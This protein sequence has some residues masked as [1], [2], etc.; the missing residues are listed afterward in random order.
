MILSFFDGQKPGNEIEEASSVLGVSKESIH[1]FVQQITGNEA[2]LELEFGG[3]IFFFPEKTLIYTDKTIPNLRHYKATDF[4]YESTDFS[5]VRYNIPSA[6]TFILNNVC[7]TDCYYCYADR[8]KKVHNEIPFER[9]KQLLH[10]LKESTIA[11]VDLIGGEVFHY[12]HWKELLLELKALA[13]TPPY[14]STKIPIKDDTIGFLKDIKHPDIQISLD[15]VIKDHLSSILKVPNSYYDSMIDTFQLLEQY[16]MPVIVHTILSK[17]NSTIEDMKSMV[18]FLKPLGNV[19]KWRID[20]VGH[21]MFLDNWQEVKPT[22]IQL[23]NVIDYLESIKKANDLNMEIIYPEKELEIKKELSLEERQDFF[24]SRSICSGNINSMFI[25]PDGKVSICEELDWNERFLIGDVTQQSITEVW[26][27]EKAK[28]I[29]YVKQEEV[30]PESACHSCKDFDKCR[31][32][33]QVCWREI[34]RAY[35]EENWDYP[36]PNCPLAPKPLKDIGIL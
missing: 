9:I 2:L 5:S 6:I 34:I 32:F 27:S 7:T 33:K 8:R 4:N 14:L 1:N 35:G 26:N 21:S 23:N 22:R 3:Q 15:T 17:Q 29:F 12:K 16:K 30:K 31:K 36:D 11:N 28:E 25:L 10:E 18:E 19:I 24:D 13:F 20:E